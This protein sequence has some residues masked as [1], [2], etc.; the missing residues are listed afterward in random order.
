MSLPLVN[1]QSQPSGLSEVVREGTY[2]KRT[3]LL[4]PASAKAFTFRTGPVAWKQN[5]PCRQVPVTFFF[6]FL[7]SIFATLTAAAFTA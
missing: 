6:H 3:D 2:G 5:F 7:R 4:N 1:D